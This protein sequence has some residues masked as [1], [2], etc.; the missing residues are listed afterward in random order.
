MTLGCGLSLDYALALGLRVAGYDQVLYGTEVPP[1]LKDLIPA[2]ATSIG[3]CETPDL[4]KI[5]AIKPDL[6][7][8]S[9]DGGNYPQL[10]EIAPTVVLAPTYATY[11]E[12]FVAAAELLGRSDQAKAHLDGLD[13]RIAA[14]KD[15]LA[16]VL[17]GKTVSFFQ[18]ATEGTTQI[19][20]T[21]TYIGKLLTDLGIERPEAQD[22]PDRLKISLEQIATLDADVGLATFGFE[23]PDFAEASEAT[24]KSYEEHPLWQTLKFVQDDELYV[25]DKTLWANYYGI[26]WA[27]GSMTDLEAKLLG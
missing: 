25:L 27:D 19:Y 1:Y 5:E 15:K 26:L 18:T 10:S 6:I 11:K 4:E 21:G 22:A 16:P 14:L 3:S 2:D 9:W 20:T 12:D 17:A 24:R 23:N 8:A 13:Q 7:V